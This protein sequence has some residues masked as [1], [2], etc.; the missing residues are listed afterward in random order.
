VTLTTIG[1]GDVLVNTIGG[2][3][4]VCIFAIFPI[5]FFSI[6]TSIVGSGFIQE[7]E[8]QKTRMKEHQEEMERK[9]K[10]ILNWEKK[11]EID[12]E[13]ELHPE[14]KKLMDEFEEQKVEIIDKINLLFDTHQK[15]FKLISE[16]LK[17]K[18]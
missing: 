7:V 6:P 15:K 14:I 9:R 18:N 2:K 1:Y 5:M 12:E 10:E 4:L 16:K 8:N 17:L 13:S 11:D 3:V